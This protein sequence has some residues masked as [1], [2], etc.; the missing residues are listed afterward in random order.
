MPSH[1]AAV[2]GHCLTDEQRIENPASPT[3]IQEPIEN[4][5]DDPGSLQ[6]SPGEVRM[7]RSISYQRLINVIKPITAGEPQ[8]KIVVDGERYTFIEHA[9][10][11]NGGGGN[12]GA[13]K[14]DE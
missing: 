3:L 2:I 7:T 11:G 13:G 1:V 9:H 5:A 10:F 6:G 4:P 14:A 8:P 12:H